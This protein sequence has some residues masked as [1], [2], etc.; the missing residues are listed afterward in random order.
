[1]F[2][3]T[4]FF[5]VSVCFARET[6]QV[7]AHFAIPNL[8]TLLETSGISRILWTICPRRSSER[9]MPPSRCKPSWT[10]LTSRNPS[11]RTG[12][13]FQRNFFWYCFLE[14]PPA[15][16][17]VVPLSKSSAVRDVRF[18][19]FWHPGARIN[20]TNSTMMPIVR[21]QFCVFWPATS[22]YHP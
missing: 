9:T 22:Q 21:S 8:Q 17:L 11:H 5:E 3:P 20:Y 13:W 15:L 4:M 16:G 10:G 18:G 6:V 19:S 12:V 2:R 1:M 14:K 7:T